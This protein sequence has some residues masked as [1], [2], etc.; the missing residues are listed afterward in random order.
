M[1]LFGKKK[2]PVQE[3]TPE[4]KGFIEPLIADSKFRNLKGEKYEEKVQ[5][6]AYE[7]KKRMFDRISEHLTSEENK[8]YF[9]MLRNGTPVQVWFA[10]LNEHIPNYQSVIIEGAHIDI[11]DRYA[12]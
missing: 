6:I 8:E 7:L 9:E 2:P 11:L 10:Y 1:P 12:E 3:I 4:L 5:E